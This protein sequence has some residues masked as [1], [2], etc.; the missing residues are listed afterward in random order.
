MRLTLT[1]HTL[2][3]MVKNLLELLGQ[4]PHKKVIRTPCPTQRKTPTSTGNTSSPAPAGLHPWHLCPLLLLP[5]FPRARGA[6]PSTATNTPGGSIRFP[7]TRGA[8]PLHRRSRGRGGGIRPRWR[9][10]LRSTGFPRTRGAAPSENGGA[11]SD[12]PIPPRPRALHLAPRSHDHREQ[13]S[14]RTRGAAPGALMVAA[15]ALPV[16]PHPRGCT[17]S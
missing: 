11:S 17:G 2:R 15:L 5:W 8:A 7:R 1:N 12:R 9:S 14:P 3:E 13:R 10:C 6:A 16:P 4:I